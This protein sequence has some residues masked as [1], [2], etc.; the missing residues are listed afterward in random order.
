[1]I[2][3]ER[4]IVVF[5]EGATTGLCARHSAYIMLIMIEMNIIFHNPG[6]LGIVDVLIHLKHLQQVAGSFLRYL[7]LSCCVHCYLPFPALNQVPSK[8][9]TPSTIVFEAL[10]TERGGRSREQDF[11]FPA[12]IL[13]FF[14]QDEVILLRLCYQ[15]MHPFR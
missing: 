11:R 7:Q 6:M 1:M 12:L 10:I 5:C 4:I 13:S 14:H 15:L 8:Y 3:P 2:P 9:I